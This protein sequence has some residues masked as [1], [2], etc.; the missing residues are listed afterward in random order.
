M[1]NNVDIKKNLDDLKKRASKRSISFSSKP[2]SENDAR[3]ENN[4]FK[5]ME[6]QLYKQIVRN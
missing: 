4:F 3:V 5:T 6:N 2:K 1:S